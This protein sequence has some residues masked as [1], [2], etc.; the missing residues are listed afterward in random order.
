MRASGPA[1]RTRSS[2]SIKKKDTLTPEHTTRDAYTVMVDIYY[3]H[4]FFRIVGNFVSFKITSEFNLKIRSNPRL[5]V[6]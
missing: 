4:F 1:R 5:S 3:L 2:S 6:Q